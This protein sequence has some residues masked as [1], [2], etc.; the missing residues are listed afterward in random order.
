MLRKTLAWSTAGLLALAVFTATSGPTAAQPAA[1][2]AIDQMD[3]TI[4]SIDGP[5]DL[6]FWSEDRGSGPKI[7]A[8]RVRDNGFPV[9]GPGGGEWRATAATGTGA[10]AGKT[11]AQRYPAFYEGV[12][13]WSEQAPGGTDYDIYA[14]RLHNNGRPR[15]N[16]FLLLDKDGD[17][18]YPDII[19]AD[20]DYIVVYSEDSTDEGDVMGLRTTTALRPRGEP[21]PIATGQGVAEDPAISRDLQEP[22]SVF[23]VLFTFTPDGAAT[24]DIYGARVVESGLPRGGASAIFPVIQ[25]DDVDEYAPKLLTSSFTFRGDQ[26]PRQEQ[27]SNLLLH[28]RHDA[29]GP[30]GADIYGQRLRSNG[31]PQGGTFLIAGGT[32]EQA[33]ATAIEG[34]SEGWLVAWQ[35]DADGDLDI[36][37]IKVRR[38][39]IPYL[40]VRPLAAD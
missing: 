34:V 2:T 37:S 19:Q 10:D 17:Q 18:L 12:L 11:G 32:G 36:H 15:G 24:K 21:F 33:F 23:V 5:F 8:K 35:D 14:Q 3:A 39:G 9:G 25:S 40:P 16:P 4:G 26:K 1:P 31:F 20:R 29:A 38:N 30:D 22:R 28:T 27:F 7:F 13:V 6:L